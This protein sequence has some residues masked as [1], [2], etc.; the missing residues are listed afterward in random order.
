MRSELEKIQNYFG[1]IKMPFTNST[2]TREL[3][4]SES[5]TEAE[6]RLSLALETEKMFMLTGESGSGKSSLLRYFTHQLDPTAYK[7]FMYLRRRI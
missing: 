1:L 2:G 6:S 4:K 5:F 3:F 7:P